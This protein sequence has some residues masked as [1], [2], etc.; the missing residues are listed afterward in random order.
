MQTVDGIIFQRKGRRPPIALVR[1]SN[2]AVYRPGDKDNLGDFLDES[3]GPP[4]L[5]LVVYVDDRTSAQTAYIEMMSERG[6]T[7]EVAG[8]FD[9]SEA[10]IDD[11]K[12]VFLDANG[13]N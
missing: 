1:P 8:P 10:S 7:G 9:M 6:W 3:G 12:L 11:W 2:G 13:S 4:R 5:V